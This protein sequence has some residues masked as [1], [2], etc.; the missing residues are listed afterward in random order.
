MSGTTSFLFQGTPT[1][2]QPTGSDT[3][4]QFPL[5]LQQYDYNLANAATN[6]ASQP[7]TPYTGQ[8]V[9]TPSADTQQA[10]NL[11]QSNVGDYQPDL[12]Q[13]NS[14]T[15]AGS[16]PLTGSQIQSYM[17]PYMSTVLGGLASASNTNFTNNVLPSIANQF[18]SSGQA[19]SPQQMQADN[20]AMY[21]SQQ[22]LNQAQAGALSQGYSTATQTAEAQQQ[23]QLQG[24]AQYGQLGALTQQLGATDVGQLAGAGS[25]Q[26]QVNQANLNVAQNNFD[27]QQQWPYQNLT[28]ASNI[29]RGQAVPSNTTQVGT[30]YLPQSSYS[31]SPLATAAGVAAGSSALGLRKGGRVKKKPEVVGA[32]SHVKRAA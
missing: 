3:S 23:A 5:W 31:A 12:T 2:A 18:V 17:N 27:Q 28:Y 20:N 7:Y 13:A 32:L 9:A 26:D 21:Q 1:P 25:A 14:L 29:I 8:Q 24:G 11:A 30:Q 15:S 22:A 16:T 4:T 10:W 6:L 19:A